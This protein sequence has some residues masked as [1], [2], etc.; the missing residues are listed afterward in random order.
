MDYEL[1]K[2]NIKL[3]ILKTVLICLTLAI[4]LIHSANRIIETMEQEGCKS[5]IQ[6]I[7]LQEYNI[8][9]PEEYLQSSEESLNKLCFLTTE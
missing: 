7:L 2:L 3:S 4:T 5:R 9:D 1:E 8:F 6:N